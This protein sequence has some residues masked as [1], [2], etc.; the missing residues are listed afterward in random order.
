LSRPASVAPAKAGASVDRAPCLVRARAGRIAPSIE[1]PACAG[2]IAG[3][4]VLLHAV[5]GV[6]G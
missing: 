3:T 5:A 1:A 2:A 6:V 4:D